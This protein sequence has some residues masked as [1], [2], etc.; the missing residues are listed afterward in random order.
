MTAIETSAPAFGVEALECSARNAEEIARVLGSVAGRPNTG[1][2]RRRD[3]IVS[4]IDDGPP[5][6][7]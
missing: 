4:S 6:W 2:K 7:R 5:W 3:H 1:L